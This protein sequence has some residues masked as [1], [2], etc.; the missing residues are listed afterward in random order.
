MLNDYA[1]LHA[2]TWFLCDKDDDTVG[3]ALKAFTGDFAEVICSFHSYWPNDGHAVSAASALITLWLTSGGDCAPEDL[4]AAFDVCLEIAIR[5]RFAPN[6]GK[7][8]ER[9]RVLV[10]R[11][12]AV[13]QQRL[14]D[15]WLHSVARRIQAAR[16]DS[17]DESRE[18]A[19]LV[20]IV[21]TII[22][23]LISLDIHG[24]AKAEAS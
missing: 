4:A 24:P 23:Q 12:L 18:P 20:R 1:W 15:D 19:E 14:P 8:R 10:L 9:F 11:H 13:N 3:H 5:A 17:S 6:Q 2:Q 21:M 16:N 22:P 7:I